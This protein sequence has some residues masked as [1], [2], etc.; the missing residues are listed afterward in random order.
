MK[1]DTF[2]FQHSKW[3]LSSLGL[4]VTDLHNITL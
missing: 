3:Y 4:K 2:K 1:N